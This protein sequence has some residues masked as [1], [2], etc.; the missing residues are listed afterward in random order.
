MNNI[1]SS[2]RADLWERLQDT[3]K[4]ILLYGTGNG[5]DKICE[6]CAHY[7]I[8][9]EGFFASDD[10]VRGQSFRG[11]T[12]LRFS[13]ACAR[14][15]ADNILVLVAFASALPDVMAN[16][17]AVASVCETYIPEVPVRGDTLFTRE[18]A[19]A[20][21]AELEEVFALLADERSRQVLCDTVR[22]RLTGELSLLRA[23]EDDKQTVMTTILRPADYRSFCDVGAYDGDT[24][25]ELLA[26]SP[27]LTR[28]HAIE[29]DRR[30]YRKLLAAV[31]GLPP[32]LN[33]TL[34][35]CAAW[36]KE[37]ALLF[38]DSG[39]RN[40]GYD[41]TAK[42]TAAVQGRQIDA[43]LDG[44]RVDYIKYDVEGSDAQALCGSAA[45]IRAQRPDLLLSLYHRT[46]D[47]FALPLLLHEICPD[48]KLR[49]RR[50]PYIP[51]WDLN[52]YAVTRG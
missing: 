39:N 15:G 8:R 30:N 5:A 7:G 23:T 16:V 17:Q 48:Y 25:R 34:H 10:F 52:L 29:P 33:V 50:Y 46:E 47:I 36:D 22:F 51:A 3:N 19:R 4:Q 12:V 20:H 26:I 43:L 2:L 6:V 45:T 31:E 41:P 21:L 37:E 38:D 44:E 42:R 40:A 28:I 18:Y 27:Q 35:N 14:Y 9:V 49:M 24:I 32:H 13:E 1:I 11:K